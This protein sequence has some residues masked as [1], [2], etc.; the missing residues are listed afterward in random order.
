MHPYGLH[1][2]SLKVSTRVVLDCL[3]IN[4]DMP[5]RILQPRGV[6]A[7]GGQG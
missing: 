6:D 2:C 3:Q 4:G 1:A 7:H 5:R